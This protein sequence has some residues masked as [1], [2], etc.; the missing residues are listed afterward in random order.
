MGTE[1]EEL[2]GVPLTMLRHT[3]HC[4]HSP[5]IYRGSGEHWL[6][7]CFGNGGTGEE[8][9]YPS[10]LTVVIGAATAAVIPT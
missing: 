3:E 2:P 7:Q 10:V 9:F 8:S 5:N 1:I 4:G 6:V